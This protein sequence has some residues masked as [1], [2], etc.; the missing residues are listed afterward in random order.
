VPCRAAYERGK[1]RSTDL[2]LV[3]ITKITR[4]YTADE[5][6]AKI[7]LVKCARL[8]SGVVV[9]SPILLIAAS[10]PRNSACL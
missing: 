3:E 1:K 8:Q 6:I 9:D 4:H 10:C 5:A 7:E 2:N